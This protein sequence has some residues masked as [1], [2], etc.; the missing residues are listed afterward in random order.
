MFV[1]D[2]VE[3]VWEQLQYKICTN[4]HMIN[5][6]KIMISSIKIPL[7]INQ[8][9][10]PYLLTLSQERSM[11]LWKNQSFF[12]IVLVLII[13]YRIKMA[14]AIIGH[15]ATFRLAKITRNK[16]LINLVICQ[17]RVT[18]RK[19]LTQFI[20]CLEELGLVWGQDYQRLLRMNFQALSGT[21]I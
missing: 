20:V 1:L 19:L 15:V 11:R 4:S 8:Q 3:F 14:L 7:K 5:L 16:L 10:K 6:Q 17:R 13:P 9:P 21:A 12:L 2:N 18:D